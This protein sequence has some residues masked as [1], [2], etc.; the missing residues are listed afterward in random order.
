[1]PREVVREYE[2]IITHEL[3]S[4]RHHPDFEDLFAV[5]R[6]YALRMLRLHPELS[7]DRLGAY[8]R[9]LARLQRKSVLSYP[10]NRFREID[11][12]GKPAERAL[13]LD[14][15]LRD[16]EMA[17]EEDQPEREWLLPYEPDFVPV[18]LTRLEAE[19]LWQHA[20][21]QYSAGEWRQIARYLSGEMH[22]RKEQTD[23]QRVQR[24]LNRLR[25]E[26]GTPL[27]ANGYI[28]PCGRM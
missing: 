19:A 1:M 13:S 26:Y 4:L 18:L 3:W 21:R 5:V 27:K 11:S 23:Y 25:Q 22:T 10:L 8:V 2:R 9:V 24:L 20:R 16:M 12:H 7:W 14:G 15:V 28:M 6:L 17:E